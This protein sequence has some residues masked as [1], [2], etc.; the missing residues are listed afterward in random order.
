MEEEVKVVL[1]AKRVRRR[2][3]VDWSI[4]EGGVFEAP[5]R[6]R[7]RRREGRKRRRGKGGRGGRR[8]E[9]VCRSSDS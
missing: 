5:P 1:K 7:G 9:A 3:V 2:V 8:E 6:E 4:V